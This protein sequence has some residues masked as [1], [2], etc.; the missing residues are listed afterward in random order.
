MA[1]FTAAD[2]QP[3]A[4]EIQVQVVVDDHDAGRGHRIELGQRPDLTAGLVHEA[5]RLGHH[6][7][8]PAQA[9]R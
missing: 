6:H 9:D 3:D 2:L 4:T 7:R 5:P 8:M 1:A